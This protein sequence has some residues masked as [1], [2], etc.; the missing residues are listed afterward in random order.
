MLAALSWF[1]ARPVD[2]RRLVALGD[3]RELG[4]ESRRLTGDSEM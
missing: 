1:F 4:A 3:M 2:G